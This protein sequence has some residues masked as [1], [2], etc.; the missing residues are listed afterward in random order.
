M[1][2]PIGHAA[3][4]VAA[5]GVLEIGAGVLVAIPSTGCVVAWLSLVLLVAVWSANNE[6]AFDAGLPGA[7]FPTNSALLPWL[8]VPLQVPLVLWALRQARRHQPAT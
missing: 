1:P 5:S 6:M 4:L 7:G 2:R 3:F 8:P